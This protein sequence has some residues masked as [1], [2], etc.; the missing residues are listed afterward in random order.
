MVPGFGACRACDL[1]FLN[2]G[3]SRPRLACESYYQRLPLGHT[4]PTTW[5]FHRRGLT[6]I[7]SLT[8]TPTCAV[9]ASSTARERT[10]SDSTVPD[11]VTSFFVTSARTSR[12]AERTCSS[13]ANID[14]T[15]FSSWAFAAFGLPGPI[16]EDAARA[17]G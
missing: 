16:G 10:A 11:S 8:T 13:C 3:D 15:A 1:S 7:L 9:F 12:S 14:L 6:V 17:S 2:Q 5:C 4:F